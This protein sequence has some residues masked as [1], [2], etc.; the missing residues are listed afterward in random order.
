[1][2]HPVY[3]NFVDAP[4]PGFPVSSRQVERIQ[5]QTRP[6]AGKSATAAVAASTLR[7]GADC[8]VDCQPLGLTP[9]Q[10]DAGE[11]TQTINLRRWTATDGAG[12]PG[13]S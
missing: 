8:Q 5:C 11:Q 7:S 10:S 4:K 13:K 9:L 2:D 3:R 6:G 12:R 1:M